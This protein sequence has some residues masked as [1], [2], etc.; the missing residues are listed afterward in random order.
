RRRG[1][2][3]P[4]DYL[5]VGTLVK[6]EAPMARSAG[7]HSTS[8]G[9]RTRTLAGVVVGVA[10]LAVVLGTVATLVLLRAAPGDI[11]SVSAIEPTV[12]GNTV[13]FTWSD[14]G[15]GPTDTFQ[16]TTG[17]G[18]PAVQQ[19]NTSFVVDAE[20]GDRVCI[21]VAVNREGKT[22]QPSGEK[23]VDVPR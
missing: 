14:P 18:A 5:G 19:R 1:A 10:A 11:P 13:E 15:L 3:A 12:S 2:S 4:A 16:V 20:P 6:D 23:C 21:T 8:R 17:G 22:G 9:K 7:T